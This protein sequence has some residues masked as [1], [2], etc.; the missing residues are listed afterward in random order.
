MRLDAVPSGAGEPCEHAAGGRDHDQLRPGRAGTVLGR[1]H[2][3]FAAVL[4]IWS[5]SVGGAS[6]RLDPV[7]KGFVLLTGRIQGHG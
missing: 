4:S 3:C 6:Y 5:W 7:I 2:H 1:G